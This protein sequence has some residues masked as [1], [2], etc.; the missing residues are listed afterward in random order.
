MK[1]LGPFLISAGARLARVYATR[2]AAIDGMLLASRRS[3]RI[4]KLRQP[5]Y[6]SRALQSSGRYALDRPTAEAV[7]SQASALSQ[8]RALEGR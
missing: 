6:A 7:R 8:A 5:V 2:M 4:G 1:I 3:P